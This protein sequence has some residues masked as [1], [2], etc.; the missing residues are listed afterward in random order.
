MNL[1]NFQILT[2]FFLIK[3]SNFRKIIFK[4]EV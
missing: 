4:N 1:I 3:E 2:K